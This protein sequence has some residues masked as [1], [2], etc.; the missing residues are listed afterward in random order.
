MTVNTY[1]AFDAARQRIVK[2]SH[3]EADEALV[4]AWNNATKLIA[5]NN[6]L[7]AQA[8]E[9]KVAFAAAQTSVRDLTHRLDIANSSGAAKVSLETMLAEAK[10]VH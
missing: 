3:T 9:H 1:A 7:L 6:R 10:S 4:F 2:K 8:E 5:E